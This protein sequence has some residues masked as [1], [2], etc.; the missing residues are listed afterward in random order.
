[1]PSLSDWPRRFELAAGRLA[2][3]MQRGPKL[4]PGRK[5]LRPHV[6][7]AVPAPAVRTTSHAR[8]V[9]LSARGVAA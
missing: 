8:Q 2:E 6:H 4:R 9:S 5:A 1:M 3:L 7:G